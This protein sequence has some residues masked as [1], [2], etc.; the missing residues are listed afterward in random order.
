MKLVL[1]G[2]ARLHRFKASG[3]NSNVKFK[4]IT[5]WFIEMLKHYPRQMCKTLQCYIKAVLSDAELMGDKELQAKYLDNCAQYDAAMVRICGESIADYVEQV[6][7]SKDSQHRVNAIELISRMLAIDATCNWELFRHELSRIP[8]EIKLIRILLQ[9]IYDQNNVVSLKGVNAFLK[10]VAD[11]NK[12]SKEII[13]VNYCF[14]SKSFNDRP[15]DF[16]RINS[17]LH[18]F[19]QQFGTGN[20]VS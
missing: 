20:F 1:N 12:Q 3:A 11:G 8:R 4:G 19:I 5:D 15:I 10:V 6:S 13:Q 17:F 14:F 2:T 18:F 16:L 9:K 7:H